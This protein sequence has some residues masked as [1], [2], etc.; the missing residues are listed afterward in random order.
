MSLNKIIT[1]E[2]CKT[3]KPKIEMSWVYIKNIGRQAW[4]CNS[5]ISL[6]LKHEPRYQT[7]RKNQFE[8][9][10]PTRDV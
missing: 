9:L 7:E 1:C 8:P 6:N 5:H 2:F 4:V 3:Q 10:E